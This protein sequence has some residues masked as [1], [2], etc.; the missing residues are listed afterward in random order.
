MVAANSLNVHGQN[1]NDT[2]SA[3]A[4]MMLKERITERYGPIRHVIGMGCSG[5]AI[6]QHMLV[7]MYPG[8]LDGIL[9]SCSFPDLWTEAKE[10][11]DCTLLSRYF[12]ARPELWPDAG[13]RNA[14]RSKGPYD[15]CLIWDQTYSSLLD[16]GADN[17]FKDCGLPAEQVYD[18]E[19]NPKGARCTIQD[20]AVAT[21]G[22]RAKDGFARRPYD[23]VGVQYGL[24]TLLSG[25]ISPAQFVDLNTT[26]GGLGIDFETTPERTVAD[27][28]ALEIAYKTGQISSGR[29]W[30]EVPII[31]LR[32]HSTVEWHQDYNSYQARARL[33]KAN[34]GHGNQV[35]WTGAAPIPGDPAFACAVGFTQ[36]VNSDPFAQVQFPSALCSAN[37]VVAMDG[38][39]ER[40]HADGS[41]RPLAA[42]VV[43]NRPDEI[44]DACFVG[45]ERMTDTQRCAELYPAYGAPRNAAGEPMAGDIQKCRRKPL[46]RED[47]NGITFSDDEWAQLAK[48]FP[49]GVCDWSQPGVAQQPAQPWVSFADGP[50]GRALGP[51]PSSREVAACKVRTV[52]LQIK[53]LRGRRLRSL[54]VGVDGRTVRV[55]RRG[56]TFTATVRI[57]PGRT[58]RVRLVGITPDR[59]RLTSV[60]RLRGCR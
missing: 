28:E 3:E 27:S 56:R 15:G 49:E 60:R 53:R 33:D 25:E 14:V 58:A 39:L 23:N 20:V 43:A 4:M 57:Q 45:G 18:R 51:P 35:I 54:R 42:K 21:W 16:P 11:A 55:R 8:L 52:K 26:I 1:S 36:T 5:G 2:V 22:R 40:I 19:T 12:Q 46:R 48:A 38:W 9:P 31:D 50:S 41:A 24:Q 7:T 34:G 37:P 10:V 30:A 44:V 17:A 32:G 59:K 29:E 13:Q 6:Q 47:Y